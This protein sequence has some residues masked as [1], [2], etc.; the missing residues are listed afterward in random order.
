MKRITI[1]SLLPYLV[2]FFGLPGSIFYGVQI[3]E[4]IFSSDTVI[5]AE[6]SHY[7]YHISYPIV[8]F[9]NN[10]RELY[11]ED[12]INSLL[13]EE[14]KDS[15]IPENISRKVSRFFA[16]ELPDY[17]DVLYKLYSIW[18]III[19]N[20]GDKE[21]PGLVLQLPSIGYCFVEKMGDQDRNEKYDHRIDLG[22]LLPGERIRVVC[23]TDMVNSDLY[24][25]E[26]RVSF[27]SGSVAINYPANV[28]GFWGWFFRDYNAIFFIMILCII[29]ILILLIFPIV[30]N[31]RRSIQ[32]K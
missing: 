10:I 23:W 19:V 6:G 8:D 26:T 3:W 4:A 25:K 24:E 9:V 29:I 18:I 2:V 30:K 20:E 32:N 21:V 13:Q 11:Y 12:K 28:Y 17:G 16:E 27:S 5:S 22:S 31:I 7:E 14:M 1:K 15:P